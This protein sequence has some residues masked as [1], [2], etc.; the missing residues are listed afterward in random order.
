LEALS[1]REMQV[2]ELIG[3]GQGTRE[4]AE[5]LHLSVHTIES[6]R[7]NIRMKLGLRNGTELLRRAVS[8]TLGDRSELA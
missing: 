8:W 1:N 7:E 3:R 2:F 5:R 4:I 6:H